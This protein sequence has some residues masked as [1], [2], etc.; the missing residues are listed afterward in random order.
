MRSEDPARGTSRPRAVGSP[1]YLQALKV[2]LALVF[3]AATAMMTYYWVYVQRE[4][5]YLTNRNFRK[6]A[7]ISHQLEEEFKSV[8]VVLRSLRP[9]ADPRDPRLFGKT[10]RSLKDDLNLARGSTPILSLVVTGVAAGV[11]TL[12]K[13][14]TLLGDKRSSSTNAAQ[15]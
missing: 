12:L 5:D 6:L 9:L 15:L 13:L 8:A 1:R 10:P 4:A 11:P 2:P 7:V 14:A 3:V